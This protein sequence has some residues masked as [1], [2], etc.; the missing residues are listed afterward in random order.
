MSQ[1]QIDRIIASNE[2]AIK[3]AQR[4]QKRLER[5]CRETERRAER[6]G[7]RLRAA[8]LLKD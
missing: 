5:A 6:A 2:K 1:E 8:G 3:D 7:K 4:V